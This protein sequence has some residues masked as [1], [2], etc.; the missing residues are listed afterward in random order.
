MDRLKFGH[1]DIH[2][3]DK[4]GIQIY[5]SQKVHLLVLYVFT[6]LQPFLLPASIKGRMLAPSIPWCVREVKIVEMVLERQP[7][8]QHCSFSRGTFWGGLIPNVRRNVVQVVDDAL[9]PWSKITTI[10]LFCKGCQLLFQT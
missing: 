10:P 9:D 2:S 4:N 8:V 3:T 5:T 7:P 1:R 6:F